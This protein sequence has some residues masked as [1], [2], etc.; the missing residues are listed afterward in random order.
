[1]YMYA[2]EKMIGIEGDSIM[3]N[4]GRKN[5]CVILCDVAD[6]YQEQ[7]CRVLTSNARVKG[8][9]LAY[10]SFFLTY[11]VDTKNGRGEANII[12]LIPYENFDGFI[13]CH[14]TFQNKDA[15]RQMFQY[16]K[17]RTKVPVITL[18]RPWEDYPCVLSK[19]DGAIRELVQHFVDV[20]GFDKI[21]FLSG[22][23][24]HPDAIERLNEYKQG[25]ES[26]NIPY[27]ESL[28]YYGNFWRDR[29]KLAARYFAFDLKE[30]P[31]AIMC[32]NDYMAL[33]VCNELISMGIMVPDDIAVTGYDDIWESTINMPP[34]TT[35][36][37]QVEKMSQKAFESLE[38]MMNGEEVPKEQAVETKIAIR[39]SCGC[40]GMDIQA[41]LKK[42]VRQSQEHE[43]LLDLV[44]NN[45]YMFVEM[46]DVASAENLVEHVRL[47]ETED[48]FVEH[49]FICLGEGRGKVYPKYCSK[50]PGYPPQM[51]AIGSVLNRRVIDTACFDTT[52][53]L[54]K[55]AMTQEPMVYYFF[56]L[57]NLQDTFG[58]FAISYQG[59]HSCEQTFHSWIA[60]LGNALENLRLKQKTHAL[61]EELNNLYI[62]DA[63]TGLL[64]RRGYENATREMYNKSIETHKSMVVFSIDMDN[65]KIVND[66]FGHAQGDLALKTIANAMEYAASEG[67]MCARIGGDEFSAF[68]LD[69]EQEEAEGFL[70]RFHEYL[71]EFNHTSQLPYNVWSSCGYCIISGIHDMTLEEA[72]VE[73]DARL[74]QEKREKKEKFVETVLR[75]EES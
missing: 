51:K 47:L 46:S 29:A 32:A 2:Y 22:P 40:E 41:M 35:V 61:L 70:R 9:N 67:T 23:K 65:L 54:P 59:E 62:H 34:I 63:L 19:N 31:Q 24:D 58:Y 45:T 18:R 8:Y 50:K 52:E 7:V 3:F 33:A 68:G 56:P 4:N 21:A 75:K 64:N 44:Q 11:G 10:F 49:F 27:D 26:R 1:M 66:Q 16:I 14:D 20:H 5:I 30:R 28:V 12:N 72:V 43:K 17:E 13:I 74:Y 73:S 48:N 55:E 6:H 38:K 57:H 71:A 42:R 25:L 39:N 60:I 69:Y 37:M 53:L 15:V 36:K